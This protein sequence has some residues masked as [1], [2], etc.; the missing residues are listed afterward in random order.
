[1]ITLSNG[2]KIRF[3]MAS[4]ARGFDGLGWKVK[5]PFE[6]I[7]GYDSELFTV[8]TKTFTLC[9]RKGMIG[10]I[11]EWNLRKALFPIT[12]SWFKKNLPPDH[13]SKKWFNSNYRGGRI[14]GW[15]NAHGLPNPGLDEFLKIHY[16][17]AL[18]AGVKPIVSIQPLDSQEART[19]V[20]RLCGENITAIEYNAFSPNWPIAEDHV[21]ET[22]I[23]NVKTMY[24]S[25]R[26][27]LILKLHAGHDH[28]TIAVNVESHVEAISFN[29]VPPKIFFAGGVKN[30]L[31]KYGGGAVSGFA[32]QPYNWPVILELS[33]ITNTPLVGS[34]P[35]YYEDIDHLL[36]VLGAKAVAF[37]SLSLASP[38]LPTKYV[39]KW[40]KEKTYNSQ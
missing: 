18:K 25:S 37:G 1:M 31:E 23:E 29:S 19:M 32:A 34:S 33:K 4:A 15:V 28:K 20:N 8:V 39:R 17:A 12:R 5:R 21:T 27:P 2:E 6:Y 9:R 26:H 36:S 13:V 14:L 7:G 40:L 22:I 24:L 38:R 35:W 3:I 30:P 10:G 16:P 11:S